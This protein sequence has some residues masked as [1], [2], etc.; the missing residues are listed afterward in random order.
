M[1]AQLKP[2]LRRSAVLQCPD[3][4]LARIVLLAD[5]RS[6]SRTMTCD[7]LAISRQRLHSAM[8]GGP[9]L[10]F[11]RLIRLGMYVGVDPSEALRAGG[12]A[13]VADLIEEAYARRLEGTTTYQRALLRELGRFPEP[14]QQAAIEFFRRIVAP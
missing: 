3:M 7:P 9:P 8:R 4:A 2:S 10:R 13:E 14:L 1:S 11:E 6:G 12:R 5:E